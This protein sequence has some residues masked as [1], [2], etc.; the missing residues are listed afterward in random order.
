[1]RLENREQEFKATSK[2]HSW[3]CSLCISLQVPSLG[4]NVKEMSKSSEKKALWLGLCA[5]GVEKFGAMCSDV[6]V[7]AS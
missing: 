2:Q 4:V 1:M 5:G 6:G 3:V 7:E